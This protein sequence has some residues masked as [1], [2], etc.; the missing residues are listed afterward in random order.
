MPRFSIV[1]PVYNVENYL[2]KCVDSVLYPERKDYEIILVNDGSTDSSGLICADYAARYP[3]L[4]RVITTENGGLGAAR[5][6]GL[7]HAQG[8]YLLFLDS[9][10]FLA[11]NAVPEM[12]ESLNTGY[13]LCI[14]DIRWVNEAGME[15]KYAHG[16]KKEG[17]L[18]LESFPELLFEYPS[19]WNKIYRRS[20]FTEN[21]IYYPGR[22][23]YEDVYVTPWLYTKCERIYS[24]HKSW[25]NYLMRS[26]SITNNKN[27]ARN[28]EIIPAVNAMLE[29]YRKEHLYEQYQPQLEYAA[30]SHQILT[31]VTRV[32]QADWRSVVQDE[33]VLDFEN[34]FPAY[35]DNPYIRKLPLKFRLIHF[36]IR[37]RLRLM[38]HLLM[39]INDKLRGK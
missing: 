33:L 38:L 28:L 37:N 16:C 12:L 6:I 21:Q 19:A 1:I 31:S 24:V 7:D 27:T 14:F 29:A 23:W 35:R 20:L 2:A 25:H 22:V 17:F 26:G 15:L 8:E 10:D 36:L 18:T 4:I 3:A 30:F 11:P 34:K 5:N 39:K 9:D 13:D 32:N